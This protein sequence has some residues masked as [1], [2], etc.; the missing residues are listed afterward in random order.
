MHTA[1]LHILQTS[2]YALY[3]KLYAD[4][5]ATD[6]TCA[7]QHDKYAV[8]FTFPPYEV[9]FRQNGRQMISE[10]M[11]IQACTLP[12][13]I[14]FLLNYFHLPHFVARFP[15]R[16]YGEGNG[17]LCLSSVTFSKCRL[18]HSTPHLTSPHSPN[19]KFHRTTS[20]LTPHNITL[21]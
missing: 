20:Q 15:V 9:W 19:I 16:M 21:F 7:C 11:N 3:V 13:V 18:R 2:L 5:V 8:S 10:L 1:T 12:N 6:T 4:T 14:P 17:N